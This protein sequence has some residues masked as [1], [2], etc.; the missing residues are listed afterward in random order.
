[1]S[2]HYT[3]STTEAVTWCNHCRRFT[4]HAVSDGQLAHCLEHE[5]QR[6]TKAQQHRQELAERAK[7]QP[8]LFQRR[9]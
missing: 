2:Q 8:Q 5:V 7:R 6:L 3:R 9:E 1:M 4:A